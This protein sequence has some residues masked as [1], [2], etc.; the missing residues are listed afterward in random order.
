MTDRPLLFLAIARATLE[1]VIFACS[2]AVLH[3]LTSGREPLSIAPTALLCF[4]TALVLIAVLRDTRA[5]RQNLWLTLIV[6]GG[7]AMFGLLQPAARPDGLAVLT[8][9]IGFGIL[10]EIF[11]WRILSVARSISR[12]SDARGSAGLAAVAVG[13]AAVVPGL[14]VAPLPALALLAVGAAGLSMSLARSTEELDLA[15]RS[16]RGTASGRTA[17]GSAL[18]I[19]ALAILAAIFSPS[20]RAL[21]EAGTAVVGPLLAQV[22]YW[23]ALPFGYLAAFLVPL[24]QPLA[25]LLFGREVRPVTPDDLLRDQQMVEALEQTRPLLFGAMEIFIAM[26]AVV[27]GIILID[28]LTRERRSPLP[29]GATLER[30]HTG[31]ASLRET[32]AGLLPHR[33]TRRAPPTD[34]GSAA[35]AVRILYWR[36][37]VLA[38]AAGAGWRA[39]PETP[40]EHWQRLRRED[41]RWAAAG[42]VVAAF[43]RVRYGEA[44]P[45]V[46][47]LEAA[48]SGYRELASRPD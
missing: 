4:G 37:L 24:F 16:A 33:K 40:G 9:I 30:E 45:S 46:E 8:R 23:I 27:F 10:G 13:V 29:D 25:R 1:A 38:E 32:L 7:A 18:V 31:G 21:A 41:H 48:R 2:A 28:R 35:A 42:P 47:A 17:A 15:G 34:D 43:E 20:L 14:D 5:Q 12:W 26:L 36:F 11:L 39:L 22:V 44:E 19:G 3:L 6:I